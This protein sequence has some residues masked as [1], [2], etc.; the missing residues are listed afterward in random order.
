MTLHK[1]IQRGR[2]ITQPVRNI[3]QH[4]R[5][6]FTDARHGVGKGA[7]SG[8]PFVAQGIKRCFDALAQGSLVLQL[9]Y[10]FTITINTFLDHDIQR[11]QRF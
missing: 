10:C 9:R 1:T 7:A 11:L 8:F 3:F 6:G 2:Q 5:D 4:R